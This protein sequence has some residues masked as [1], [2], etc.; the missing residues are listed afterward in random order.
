MYA[1]L[2]GPNGSALMPCILEI[3]EILML[4]NYFILLVSGRL[5][6]KGAKT[7]PDIAI[8][9]KSYICKIKVDLSETSVIIFWTLLE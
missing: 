2:F 5:A 4:R 8:A 9:K 6:E 1:S 7:L 3:L